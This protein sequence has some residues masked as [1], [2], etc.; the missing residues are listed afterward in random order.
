MRFGQTYILLLLLLILPL[1]W[2]LV[3]LHK[4]RLQRFG[5]FAEAQFYPHYFARLSPFYSALRLSLLIAAFAFIVIALAR[6]Q[7]DYRPQ[8]LESSG[9]DLI[10]CI[11]VSKSMDA[12]DM[13][14]SRLS[15]AQLQI[16]SFVSELKGDRI[17]IIAFAG[18]PSLECPLTDDYD[19]VQ[20]VINSLS[21]DTVGMP[22]SDLGAA[23]ELAA[24]AFDVGDGNKVLVLI[25]DGEDL[26]EKAIKRASSLKDMG[27]TIYT[28]GVGSS[29]GSLIQNPET[30]EEVLTKL[31]A[32]TLSEIATQ[33][34]GKYYNVTPSQSEIK[35][36][37][38][39][40]FGL[41]RSKLRS[42]EVNAMKDQY[43]IF[44]LIALALF[45]SALGISPYRKEGSS[46]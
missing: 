46:R 2:L 25:S 41:E 39:Q 33:G 16:A 7:W 17:G 29:Q 12:T 9:I 40:I 8:A 42:R 34:G 14:P 37:L 32:K 24:K 13:L 10:C 6:P 27:I 20:M 21:T 15:R 28:M 5:S 23:L 4:R 26:E 45:A 31:D 44:L 3:R 38:D 35:I 1:I 30:G 22:G 11:D 43:H 36:L 18:R 19:A